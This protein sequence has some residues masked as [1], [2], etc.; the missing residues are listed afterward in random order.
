[1][2]AKAGGGEAISFESTFYLSQR[3]HLSRQ[4]QVSNEFTDLSRCLEYFCSFL[5]LGWYFCFQDFVVWFDEW[6]VISIADG[7]AQLYKVR[8]TSASLTLTTEISAP[9]VF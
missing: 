4:E 2:I 7:G 8:G 1:M 3:S 9:K 5:F 6:I